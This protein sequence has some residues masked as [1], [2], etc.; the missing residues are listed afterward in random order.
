M[1]IHYFL[2][3]SG[4]S[5]VAIAT[6]TATSVALPQVEENAALAGPNIAPALNPGLK[7]LLGEW[8]DDYMLTSLPS[9]LTKKNFRKKKVR[10]ALL[11]W[12]QH[13]IKV[14]TRWLNHQMAVTQMDNLP[15]RLFCIYQYSTSSFFKKKNI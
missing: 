13:M 15:I 11:I 4:M 6:G 9:S 8:I 1:K 2:E 7:Y 14:K 10:D 12:S 3:S 5:T